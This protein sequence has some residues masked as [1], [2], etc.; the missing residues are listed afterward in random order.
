MWMMA[1]DNS[2]VLGWLL[3]IN[4]LEFVEIFMIFTYLH[5]KIDEGLVP[6][7]ESLL[8]NHNKNKNE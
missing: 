5:N 1:I 8:E 6:V 7:T 3:L 4:M 2:G